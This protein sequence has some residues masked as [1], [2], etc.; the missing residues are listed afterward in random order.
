MSDYRLEEV[1]YKGIEPK[2]INNF[3]SKKQIY[4]FV[5]AGLEFVRL[6]KKDGQK[7][8]TLGKVNV[9]HL[10]KAIVEESGEMISETWA[11]GLGEY[12]LAK[13]GAR[14]L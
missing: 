7:P 3:A 11:H 5:Y 2:R 1:F 6:T 9:P 12:H 14:R 4:V 10:V 8:K 13:S